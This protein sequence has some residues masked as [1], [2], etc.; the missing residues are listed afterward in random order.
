[1]ETLEITPPVALFLDGG[2]SVYRS[3]IE[4]ESD[5]EPWYIERYGGTQFCFGYDANARRL[6]FE[7]VA[8]ERGFLGMRITDEYPK[9]VLD[10][11]KSIEDDLLAE[12]PLV[13]WLMIQKGIDAGNLPDKAFST[14]R[15]GRD[16]L[17]EVLQHAGE[18]AGR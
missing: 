5:I 13:E 12:K 17:L 14:D 1:M 9:L 7:V 8:R 4:A 3:V 10:D 2:V 18:K 11:G 16:L 15:S 6:R